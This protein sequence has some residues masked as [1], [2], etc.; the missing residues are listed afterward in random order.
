[1]RNESAYLSR[2]STEW[3]LVFQ[4]HNGPPAEVSA[5]QT[6]LMARYAGA[7]H[8]YLLGALRDPDL[9]AELDQEFALRFLRGDLHRADPTRGRFRDFLKR[10]LRNLMLDHLRKRRRQSAVS[11]DSDDVPEPIAP[12]QELPDFDRQFTESWRRE[13]M[14][15]AWAALSRH[16]E[17]TGQPLHTVLQI[18]SRN[19]GK[20][21]P[22]LA[23]LLSAELGKPIS[24]A[25]VREA[26]F[27]ARELFVGALLD[28]VRASLVIPSRELIVEELTELGLL[29]Y[30][31]PSLKRRGLVD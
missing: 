26:L 29:D 14:A 24:S 5:A 1:M 31:R 13:L 23:V 16:Q 27:R 30:C 20:R 12:E 7:V 25:W 15:Q 19:P 2:I 18:R 11:I 21:S 22:E 10:A 3:D 9:A 8:R 28:G 17:Q 6:R 4:A